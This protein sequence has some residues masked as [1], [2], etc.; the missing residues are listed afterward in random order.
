MDEIIF[1]IVVVFVGCSTTKRERE[2]ERADNLN[3]ILHA[4]AYS[5]LFAPGLMVVSMHAKERMK[6]RW[7]LVWNLKL[8]T[9]IN[10][11]HVRGKEM[12]KT[13]SLSL[14]TSKQVYLIHSI[15]SSLF[16]SIA[17]I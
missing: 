13:L 15:I 7:L 14:S 12:V 8:E 3:N 17:T 1:I 9:P 4:R 6:M 16:I 11:S 5:L 10:V 2:K